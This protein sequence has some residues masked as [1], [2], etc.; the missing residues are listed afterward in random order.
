MVAK[1]KPQPRRT[2]PRHLSELI[3]LLQSLVG[4]HE[5]LLGVIREKLAAMK[6]ADL[7]AMREAACRERTLASTIHEREGLRRQ[8]MDL[9][10]DEMGLP[11]KSA[12]LFTVSQLEAR[13]PDASARAL[14]TAADQLLH[15]MHKVAQSNRVAGNACREIVNH[16]KWVFEAVRPAADRPVGYAGDGALVGPA[17]TKIFEAMG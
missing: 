5:E 14:R 8:L 11:P 7:H 10:G 16:M 3:C 12:R 2:E 13:L 9:I 1:P 4:T 6:R 17:P 15:V